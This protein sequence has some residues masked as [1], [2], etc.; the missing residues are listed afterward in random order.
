[1]KYLFPLLIVFGLIFLTGCEKEKT[2]IQPEIRIG[3][4]KGPTA[5]SM[6]GLLDKPHFLVEKD[7]QIN[8]NFTIKA[9][10][11][12]LQ[13]ELIKEKLDMAVIPTT[14][15]AILYNKGIDYRIS[16]ITVWG[17]LVLVGKQNHPHMPQPFDWQSL[18]GKE[19]H[20]MGKGMTPDILFH[21][22][23]EKKGL[24]NKIEVNFRFPMPQDLAQAVAAGAVQMAVLSEPMASVALARNEQLMIYADLTRE[25]QLTMGQKNALPQAALI[26]K[27]SFAQ[28][29]P[30]WVRQ[31]TDTYRNAIESVNRHP[32]QAAQLMV[33]HKLVPQASIAE[34]AIPRCH[35][36]FR[37]AQEVKAHIKNYLH[38]FF[39]MNPN[40]VGGRLP[41]EN[42]YYRP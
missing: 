27:S 19:V 30:D 25:W 4:L 31:F 9:N 17:T 38:L 3:L 7:K 41:D 34:A 5:M 21:L 8:L 22:L 10:P 35:L 18:K 28:K 15:A 20:L 12:L 32:R 40:I 29:K 6:I 42:F 11:K 39:Q 14:L 2:G 37:P 16:A 1:M 26:I 13:A 24:Q 23:L 33:K 36:D